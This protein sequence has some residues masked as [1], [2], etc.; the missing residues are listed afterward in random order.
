[1]AT[2]TEM[3]PLVRTADYPQARIVLHDDDVHE[4]G[5]VV[6]FLLEAVPH[7]G[8]GRCVGIMREAH[9]SG[10]AVVLVAPFEHAEGYQE[11]LESRGLRV[12]LEP[13]S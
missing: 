8:R 13:A 4:M 5:E 11:R 3:R 9:E 1:M 2:E 6:R 7:L 12:T 10:S